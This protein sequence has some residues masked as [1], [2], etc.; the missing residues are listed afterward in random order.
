MG[1]E[2]AEQL[3]WKLPDNVI[4]PMAGGSLINKIDKAFNEFKQLGFVDDTHR[5]PRP[6]PGRVD[7]R[8]NSAC[9]GV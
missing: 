7:R 5:L 2:I 9:N 8:A 4:V 1:F 6:G 3:G